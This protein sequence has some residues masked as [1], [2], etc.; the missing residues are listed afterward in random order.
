MVVSVIVPVMSPVQMYS[1]LAVWTTSL[2]RSASAVI[3]AITREARL[4]CTALEALIGVSTVKFS[5]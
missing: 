3:A 2:P 5:G 1:A 4:H